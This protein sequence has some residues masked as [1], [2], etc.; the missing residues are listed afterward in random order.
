MDIKSM[1]SDIK[2]LSRKDYL[3]YFSFNVE[4]SSRISDSCVRPY[5]Y[6]SILPVISKRL[7]TKVYAH[8]FMDYKDRLIVSLSILMSILVNCVLKVIFY[9]FYFTR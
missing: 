6:Q 7:K 3:Y 9:S 2:Y 5:Q 4:M 8:N 1:L